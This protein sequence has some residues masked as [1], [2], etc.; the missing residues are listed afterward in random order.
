MLS[1]FQNILAFTSIYS[2]ELIRDIS[3]TCYA[4]IEQ[5]N[6]ATRLNADEMQ[7]S[8]LKESYHEEAHIKQALMLEPESKLSLMQPAI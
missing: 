3:I 1:L 6:S 4:F 2:F 5:E 8:N 7:H